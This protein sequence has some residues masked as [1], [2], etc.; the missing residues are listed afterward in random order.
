M[1]TTNDDLTVYNT[2]DTYA[3]Y[4]ATCT[5]PACP[6]NGETVRVP[7]FGDPDVICGPCGAKITELMLAA[8]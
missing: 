8:D 2:E 1:P 7:V 4:D 5:N 3:L 6:Y